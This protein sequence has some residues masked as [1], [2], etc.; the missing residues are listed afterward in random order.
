MIDCPV[1]FCQY[2]CLRDAIRLQDTSLSVYNSTIHDRGRTVFCYGRIYGMIRR[3]LE[4]RSLLHYLWGGVRESPFDTRVPIENVVPPRMV[5]IDER[6]IVNKMIIDRRN[7]S[8]R[9]KPASSPLYPP[10]I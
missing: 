3:R 7:R 1:M 9:K 10:Q 8:T 2:S 5:M 6:G 4:E